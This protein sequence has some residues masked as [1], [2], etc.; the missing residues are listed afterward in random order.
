MFKKILGLALASTLLFTG[1]SAGNNDNSKETNKETNKEEIQATETIKF[2]VGY[3]N[4]QNEPTSKAVEKWAELV[5]EKSDGKIEFELFPNSSLGS[6]TDLM[7]QMQIGQ[8]VITVADAA[9]LAEYGVNDYGIL[10]APY[11]FNNWDEVWK[12]IDSDW[13]KSLTDELAKK[14]KIRVL[15]SNWIYGERCFMTN[16]KVVVPKDIEGL[17]VRVS[18]NDIAI[19][20]FENLGVSPVAMEM[21]DVYT[22]LQT[23]MIDGVENPLVSLSNRSFDE[24]CKYVVKNN[25]IFASQIWVC[26]EEFFEKLTEEERQ[27][28][29][30]AANEAGLYNNE[31]YEEATNEAEEKMKEN[32]VEIT[33]LNEEEFN[34]WVNKG[35]KFFDLGKEFG[36]SDNLYQTIRDLV[37]K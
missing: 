2:Q 10:Y 4:N 19:K 29:I 17:K 8:P 11:L 28:V 35:K 22:S 21:G 14:S 36:W 27:I 23:K 33:E 37:E 7:D 24:V 3:E 6:K 16:K 15:S 20:S 13:Y 12:A 31:L 25:H 34:E 1:C 26:S 5:K 18:S 32:G 30:D 9:Y